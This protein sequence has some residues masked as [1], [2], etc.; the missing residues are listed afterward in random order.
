[1]G[2][3]M[4][5]RDRTVATQALFLLNSPFVKEQA[6][7]LNERLAAEAPSDEAL[8]LNELYLLVLNRPADKKETELALAF[9]DA[10]APPNK[11]E[12]VNEPLR[13][14]AWEQLCH[15]I[16]VSNSFLFKE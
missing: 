10:L 4:C 12:A 15:G 5:I 9:L 11:E 14:V 7:L 8:R 16:L 2:S 1:M 6:K 3:E 13:K